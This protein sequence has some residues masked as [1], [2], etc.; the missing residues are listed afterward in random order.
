M[1]AKF[2]DYFVYRLGIAKT[3]VLKVGK[4]DNLLD[5]GSS[6]AGSNQSQQ[7]LDIKLGLRAPYVAPLNILQ[8]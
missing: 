1:Y 8:V 4:K 5:A 2:K 7:D 6:I 3:A